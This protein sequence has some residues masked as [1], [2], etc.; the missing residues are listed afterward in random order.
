MNLS[1]LQGMLPH[2]THGT[3][4]SNLANDSGPSDDTAADKFLPRHSIGM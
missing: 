1:Q 2:I 4:G 3:V